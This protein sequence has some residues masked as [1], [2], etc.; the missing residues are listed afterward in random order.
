M[1]PAAQ[2]GQANDLMGAFDF[3][4]QAQQ[5]LVLKTRTCL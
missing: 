5:P 3:K 2:D 1:D 4:Q